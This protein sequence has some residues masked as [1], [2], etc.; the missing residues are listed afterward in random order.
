[1]G[2]QKVSLVNDQ[3]QMQ[4]FVKSLLNDV[5]ALEYM[6]DNDWFESDIVRLGAEQEMVMVD[7]STFKPSLVAMEALEKMQHYPWV[8]TELA[9]FNLETNIEPR[10]FEKDC[11]TQL[12]NENT[13]K[14]NKIQEVLDGMNTSIVLTGILPTLRKYHLEMENL[15]PKK[16]Y[17]ALMESLN[18]QLIGQSYELRIVGIDELLV[19]HSS[20]LLEA[21]NTSFQV[22]LQVAP[23]DFVKMYNIAQALAGPMMAISAN[24]PIVFGKRLW[25]E[26]RIALFQQSLD[27]RTSHDHMRERSPRVSFGRDWLHDSIMEIYKEDIA[28][29]RVLLSSDVEEDSIDMIKN[30]KVP[31]LHALQVHNSTVYRWNRPCYGISENGKPHLRIENRIL[32]AGPTVLDEVAN[33]CF[34]LGCMVGMSMEVEDIRTRMSFADARDNFGKAAKFG[35]DSKFTW[36]FDEKISAEQLILQLLPISRKGL[37]SRNVDAADI[38][39]YLHVIE[40][41]AVKNMTGARWMLR[42]YTKLH[43]N[44]NTDEALSVL[45]A[46]MIQ[47]QQS[48]RPVH[49]WELPNLDDL[50]MY[51]PAHLKVS[52]FMLTDL[53]TVQK[54]D[55]VDFVAELMDWNTIRFTP[56]EDTKGKLVG[57]VTA[58]LLL[59]HFMKAKQSNSKKTTLVSEIMI[60]NP[61]TV[62]QDTNILEAM[63]LM[64][65]N[66]IGCLPVVNGD[67]LVGLISEMEFLRITARLINRV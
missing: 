14:L 57:L 5:T 6:L 19:K 12:E 28:R 32:P 49:E 29:F 23:C 63:K 50:K 64:R 9:K 34:W 8:E 45:T 60:H 55:I 58:R 20:P 16:R 52:E 37:E 48:N 24:S 51:R 33:A 43:E 4:K 13:E 66:K 25:H 10:V 39:K 18:K 11:F 59:R 56:V 46:T 3:K 30:N 42:A 35:I 38:D 36:F 31:K 65:E 15:T 44:T 47:N 54:D 53:Y 7:K 41:R 61:V 62:N 1:M 40:Q 21:S 17:F 27:T 2:E 26:T 22:H 67:E